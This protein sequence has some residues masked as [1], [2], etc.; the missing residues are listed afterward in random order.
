[1]ER[2]ETWPKDTGHCS[3]VKERVARRAVK[4]ESSNIPWRPSSTAL[5]PFSPPIPRPFPIP[6]LHYSLP[7]PSHPPASSRQA[8]IATYTAIY[9]PISPHYPANLIN[10]CI[11]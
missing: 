4:P 11:I 6:N 7:S 3:K 9:R 1:M 5:H 8:T 2:P 10:S